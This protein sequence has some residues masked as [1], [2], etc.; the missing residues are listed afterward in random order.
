MA[1]GPG[2]VPAQLPTGQKYFELPFNELLAGISAKQKQ[3]DEVDDTK[4]KIFDD[5]LK[6]KPFYESDKQYVQQ[7]QNKLS[8][9]VDN[10]INKYQGD[11]TKAR[12]EI[13]KLA[14]EINQELTTGNLATVNYNT[15]EAAKIMEDVAKAKEKQEFGQYSEVIGQFPNFYQ[16][17]QMQLKDALDEQG[18]LKKLGFNGIHRQA[19][20]ELETNNLFT[21]IVANA[22]QNKLY[23][24]NTGRF[25]DSGTEAITKGKIYST[26]L[27]AVNTGLLTPNFQAELDYIS[28]NMS[29]EQL[30]NQANN[31]LNKLPANVKN[32][33]IKDYPNYNE[34]PNILKQFTKANHVGSQG[35]RFA[36]TKTNYDEGIDNTYFDRLLKQEE[37][38][39]ARELTSTVEDIVSVDKLEFPDLIPVTNPDLR[40]FDDKGN[41]KVKTVG[42]TEQLLNSASEQ[43]PTVGIAPLKPEMNTQQTPKLDNKKNEQNYQSQIEYLNQQRK[44]NPFLNNKTDKVAYQILDKARN[45]AAKEQARIF[46]VSNIAADGLKTKLISGAGDMLE[47]TMIIRDGLGTEK[48]VN[49]NTLPSILKYNNKADFDKAV[50]EATVPGFSLSISEIPAAYQ[51]NIKDAKGNTRRLYVSPDDEIKNIGNL[52]NN[53]SKQMRIAANTGL[54]SEFTDYDKNNN[55]VKITIIPTLDPKSEKYSFSIKMKRGDEEEITTFDDI[56]EKAKTGIQSSNFLNSVLNQVLSK[57]PKQ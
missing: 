29:K 30:Q 22:V 12:P 25:T 7:V 3:F 40:D 32:Q 20:Q 55:P 19:N 46:K 43:V 10:I 36:F 50:K 37:E 16:R 11:L 57:E 24:W 15:A 38:K 1:I 54:E 13:Q 14:R 28:N 35:E 9:N 53:V 6:V 8:T 42:L 56:V 27:N 52:A 51:M 48:N 33:I 23:D 44:L 39:S 18:N 45:E 21:D 26:A 41:L 2:F 47:R 4:N 5:L 31:F 17:Q 34:N 49:W